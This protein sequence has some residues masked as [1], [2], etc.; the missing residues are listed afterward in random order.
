MTIKELICS[1]ENPLDNMETIDAILDAYMD[2]TNDIYEGLTC[3]H[4]KKDK[5][6]KK[7]G[8]INNQ[9]RD[10]F[11][12]Y[13]FNDWKQTIKHISIKNLL[14]EEKNKKAS[15]L[16]F[17][18]KGFQ[19]ANYKEVMEILNGKNA[20]EEIRNALIDFRWDILEKISNW[21]H[22]DSRLIYGKT[23]SRNPITHRLY[24]NCD[25]SLRYLIGLEFMKKCK[26]RKIK[27]DFKFN[28]STTRD[29]AMVFYSDTK[30]L[31]KYVEILEE[32]K[33]EYGLADYI[34]S[35]PILTG[36][37]N[38]WIGYGSEPNI[39]GVRYSFNSLRELHLKN[40]M[41]KE[42][43]SWIRNHLN[44]PVY[45]NN[46]KISY[47]D[48]LEKLIIAQLKNK[49]K[50]SSYKTLS[51]EDIESKELENSLLNYIRNHFSEILDIFEG[52]KESF[53]EENKDASLRYIVIPYK[54]QEIILSIFDLKDVFCKQID[55]LR[56]NDRNFKERLRKRIID[57]SSSYG[58]SSNYAVDGHVIPMFKRELEKEREESAKNSVSYQ[59]VKRRE[60]TPMTEEEIAKSRKKLGLD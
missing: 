17:Y 38:G 33:A 19:P 55:L 2:K 8:N 3:Y 29:D 58:I 51:E 48:Y 45:L 53:A 52:K 20:S 12:V 18:L 5:N 23:H 54:N 21:N 60:W 46:K 44:T 7:I 32:I 22:I 11:Y 31:K 57:T 50:E 28:D 9:L 36:K 47:Q 40:C 26:E 13:I 6:R 4:Y 59:K 25:P 27:F 37:I 14:S 24:I 10:N 34:Y 30:N 56:K 1:I 42:V 49:I 15:I 41:E 35:P 43:G 16:T 39:V